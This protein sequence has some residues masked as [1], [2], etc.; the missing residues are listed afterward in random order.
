MAHKVELYKELDELKRRR[1]PVVVLWGDKDK[2]IPQVDSQA[3]CK[4]LGA[5][6]EVLPGGHSWLFTEPE[7]FTEILTNV[8]EVA[9][10]NNIDPDIN[11]N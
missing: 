1:L 6:G 3:L 10:K 5:T 9:E 11:P 8:L 4:A 2:I 7:A